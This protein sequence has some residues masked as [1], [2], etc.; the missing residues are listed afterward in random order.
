MKPATFTGLAVAAVISVCL[1]LLVYANANTWISS[2]PSGAKVF[3]SLPRDAGRIA[4]IAIKRGEQEVTL[5]RKG[6]AWTI[7]ERDAYPASLDKIRTLLVK[8]AAAELVEPKTKS[9][10]R[11]PL[12]NLEDPAQKDA[13]SVLVRIADDRGGS[14]AELVIGK[15]SQEQLGTGKSGTYVRKPNDAQTWL[16]SGE[17]ATPSAV[18]SWVN[19]TFFETEAA[20]MTRLKIEIPGEAPLV[21]EKDTD[22]GGYKLS[23]MPADR[24]LKSDGA[25]G[26]IVDAF[27]RIELEDMRKLT[28]PAQGEAVN[29]ATFE[30][31]SG[32]KVVGRLRRDGD[33]RW[34]SLEA[35]V[36][37]DAKEAA[38]RIN[39]RAAGWEFKI[40][41]WKADQIF[42]RRPDLLETA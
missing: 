34:L 18:A 8:L 5:E 17:L 28:A 1:A 13:K 7:K 21:V 31:E 15:Q 33:N 24:K 41:S 25:L 42:K 16:A 37:G 32:L 12:L 27:A 9:P 29:T 23:D 22:K 26:Q 14:I 35:Q 30:A 10:D 11:Y 19:T 4:S 6:E 40:S 20:K 38:E 2:A 3:P 39:A 36:T